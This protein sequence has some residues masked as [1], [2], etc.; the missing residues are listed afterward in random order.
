MCNSRYLVT[1][2]FL[3][4]FCLVLSVSSAQ[5]TP[6]YTWWRP[7]NSSFPVV[8]G[9]AWPKEMQDTIQRLPP[10]AKPVVRKAVWDLSRQTAGLSIRFVSNAPGIIVRYNVTGAVALPHMPATGVS[11]VDLYG[12][13]SDGTWHLASGKYSFKDTVQYTFAQLKP[14]DTYHA[15]GREY[16]LYLPLYNGVR[17]LE[18][19]VP[20]GSQ[21]TVLPQRAEKPIVV[22]G[23]SIAQGACASRPG[24]AWTNILARKLDQTVINLGFSGNGRLEKEVIELVN[25]IDAKVFVLDCLPNLIETVVSRAELQKRI[26]ESVKAIRARHPST[27]ILLTDHDS[28]TEGYLMPNRQT[29]FENANQD[30]NEAYKL[31]I[32][33]NVTGIYRLS[34]A[35]IGMD[36]D[37]MVDGTHPNDIG[38][39]RYAD[40]YEKKL[41][42]ILQQPIGTIKTQIPTRQNREPGSY[43]W[44]DRHNDML[45]L[46]QTEPTRIVFI[47]NS[48]THNW[49]GKPL[50][51]RIAGA[52][53]WQKYLEPLQVRNFGF[54]WDRVENVLWRVYHDELDG[55][56]PEQIVIN[57]GTNNLHL[58]TDEEIIQ[59]LM[60][61]VQAIRLHQP[62]AKITLLG[63]YPRREQEGRVA[64]LNKGIQAMTRSENI[65]YQDIGKRLLLTGGKI[66]ERLFSDGL[67]PNAAG[68]ELLGKE[69]EKVLRSR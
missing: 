48:I 62:N 47:G 45:K 1:Y 36:L 11:G 14:N 9:Q 30:L 5:T 63:I 52:D 61:L 16:R 55:I 15:L 10:R 58:N 23:T 65:G 34:M 28:Y 6:S 41:R 20:A 32:T 69:L 64:G 40:A 22:Y 24:M 44:E 7:A 27:P 46:N 21:F 35:E 68:Y 42:E 2:L 19:G 33:D 38:M 50:N 66:D 3:L 18:I 43:N 59:G 37:C 57:I 39:M 8:D 56:S 49:G 51:N 26:V 31:L 29:L 17:N 60:F 13:D 54:G 4:L 12:I 53:S 25:E 67:H